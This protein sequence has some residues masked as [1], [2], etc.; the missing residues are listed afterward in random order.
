MGL[1]DATVFVD[2]RVARR[3][4]VMIDAF[5]VD[6]MLECDA[7]GM[8]FCCCVEGTGRHVWL[9]IYSR[10]EAVSK[11][12]PDLKIHCPQGNIV[13]GQCLLQRGILHSGISKFGEI[14]EVDDC[15]C[16]GSLCT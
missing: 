10:D 4:I 2:D 3:M 8:V 15:T 12:L 9:F 14:Q 11:L 7:G 6:V 1:S 16:Y 5:L 13:L